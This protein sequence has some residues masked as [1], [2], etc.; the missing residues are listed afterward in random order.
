M[1]FPHDDPDSFAR[2]RVDLLA[3]IEAEAAATASYT[4]RRRFS[5]E[6]MAAMAKVPRHRFVPPG[7]EGTA[8]RKSVV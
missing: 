5:P 4:G 2:R 6:V 1:T 8:D 7:L 3:E